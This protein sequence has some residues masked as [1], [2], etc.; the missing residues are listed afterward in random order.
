MT[1]NDYVKDNIK[2]VRGQ[3]T[4]WKRIFVKHISIKAL[5]SKIY[6]KS[7]FNNKKLKNKETNSMILKIGKRPH[8]GTSLK[9]ICK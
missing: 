1:K 6:K 2:R 9:K 4:P 3:A 7:K 8:Q 5:V